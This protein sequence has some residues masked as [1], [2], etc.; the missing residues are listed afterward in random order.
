MPGVR[1]NLAVVQS[2]E[3][4]E[5]DY[6]APAAEEKGPH[7]HSSPSFPLPNS[8]TRPTEHDM[9]RRDLPDLRRMTR[10]LRP[11]FSGGGVTECPL[12]TE[13]TRSAAAAAQHSFV[14]NM[15]GIV[16]MV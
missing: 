4:T 13:S 16:V 8:T 9:H 2:P 3:G 11:P 14:R 12:P 1:T 10:K 15:Q 7:A 5:G 6:D